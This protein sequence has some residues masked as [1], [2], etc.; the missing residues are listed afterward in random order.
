MAVGPH[1]G[2]MTSVVQAAMIR[3][4]PDTA[5]ATMADCYGTAEGAAFPNDAHVKL[6]KVVA[7]TFSNQG[8]RTLGWLAEPQSYGP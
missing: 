1:A 4:L 6:V 5:R 7:S 8:M 3:K 2:V